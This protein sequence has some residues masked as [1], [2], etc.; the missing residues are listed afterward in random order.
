MDS[1]KVIEKL[2]KIAEK[3]QHMI[4]KLAQAAGL[5]PQA[6][7]VPMDITHDVQNLLNGMTNC[8][9]C[10][11]NQVTVNDQGQVSGDIL[12]PVGVKPDGVLR[13]V[14]QGLMGKTFGNYKVSN[15]SNLHLSH[16]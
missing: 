13:M 1:K 9:G 6:K 12:V 7:S 8:P 2:I 10:T 11:A 16:G 15:V 14:G 5:A 4:E 3:Q